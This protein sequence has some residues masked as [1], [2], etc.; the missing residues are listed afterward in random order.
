MKV[1]LRKTNQ[2]MTALFSLVTTILICQEFAFLVSL[3]IRGRNNVFFLG[4][5]P[6]DNWTQEFNKKNI[7]GG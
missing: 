1:W 4:V 3:I 6:H 5:Y 2:S 7:I